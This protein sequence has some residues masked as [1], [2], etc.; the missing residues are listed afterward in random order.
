MFHMNIIKCNYMT[1]K[2]ITIDAPVS[3]PNT[4]GIHIGRSSMINIT[5]ATIRTGDD[6]VSLGDGSQHIS[7]NN[8]TCGP[9]HGISVG[10]LGKYPGEQPVVGVIVRNCTL[11]NTMNGLR[12]KTWP[13]SFNGIASGL[14][15]QDIIMDNV[16]NPVLIDQ[17]YCP[18]DLCKLQ[19][20]VAIILH[21]ACLVEC[22]RGQIPWK[23]NFAYNYIS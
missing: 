11:V 19:V 9:G 16:S 13:N 17:D 20:Y 5:G 6:C 4:D 18:D 12:V 3:S 23:F 7:I 10:S 22:G 8:I 1:F 21:S 2:G 14:H 15:F